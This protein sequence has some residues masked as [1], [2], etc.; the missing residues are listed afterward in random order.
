MKKSLLY[1]HLAVILFGVAGLFGKWITL[2]A[3]IITLGR[4]FFAFVSLAFYYFIS[5]KSIKLNNKTDYTKLLLQG[6]LLAFH[7][8]TF[9]YSVQLSTVA[10]ALISVSTF[11]VF[12][13]FLEPLFFKEKLRFIDILFSLITLFGIYLVVPEFD[14]TNDYT[15]G[16]ISGV[17]SG[18]SFSL[19]QVMNRKY[20]KKYSGLLI[21]FYQTAAATI[22]L[23]PFL[24][25]DIVSFDSSN[26]ILLILL[27]IIFTALAHSM[28]IEG[29]KTI[30][31]KTASIIA[32]LEPVYGILLALLLINEIPTIK[33]ILGGLIILLVNLLI[34]NKK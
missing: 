16:A 12:T 20:V 33:V 14:I 5:G 2:S 4:V 28:F 10:I 18:F 13:A 32:G 22:V 24:L 11:P 1:I 25:I 30:K 21:T 19:L 15:L 9:F 34:V 23:I 7:W 3:I 29:L 6:V 17:I 31:V 27:G 8:S 26:I